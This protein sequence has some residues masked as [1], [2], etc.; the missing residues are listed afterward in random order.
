MTVERMN[1]ISIAIMA[2]EDPHLVGDEEEKFAEN[3]AADIRNAYFDRTVIDMP[4][5]MCFGGDDN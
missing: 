2:G 1:R 3:V 5:E 4:S